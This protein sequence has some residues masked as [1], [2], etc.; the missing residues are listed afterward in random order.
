MT[1]CALVQNV[2]VVQSVQALTS[3]LLHVAGD[4]GGGL[5][6][7]NFLNQLNVFRV[8]RSKLRLPIA[9]AV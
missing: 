8:T 3:V 6:D 5:N 9:L 1:L 4:E 2:Q 7:W